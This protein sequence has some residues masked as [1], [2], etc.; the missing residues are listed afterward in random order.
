MK[1]W[2]VGIGEIAKLQLSEVTDNRVLEGL[3]KRIDRLEYEPDKQGK[4][5]RKELAGLRTIRAVGQRY[6]IIYRVQEEQVSVLV[7]IVGKRKDGDKNDV[8]AIAER[9]A[10]LGKLQ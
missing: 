3:G 10:R 5:L 7:V 6:R 8:Y 4:P 9:L 2:T 1:R